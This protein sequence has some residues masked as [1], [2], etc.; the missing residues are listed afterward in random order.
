MLVPGK[1][2][3]PLESWELHWSMGLETW[4]TSRLWKYCTYTCSHSRLLLWPKRESTK[5]SRRNI[6]S[7]PIIK[8]YLVPCQC[9]SSA[10]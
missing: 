1:L 9:G 2:L 10:M 3:D 5:R 4:L 7:L 6:L 8:Y